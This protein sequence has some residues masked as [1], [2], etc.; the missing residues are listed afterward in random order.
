MEEVRG[1]RQVDGD[2][3]GV[4]LFALAV[5]LAERWKLLLFGSLAA[6]LA[7]LGIAFVIPPTFT[8]RTTFLPPQQQ[9]STV[10]SLLSSLGPLAGLAGGAAGLRTPADQYVA[11]MQSAT[12]ADRIIDGFQL[13]Q[14]YDEKLRVDARKE[15]AKNV[16]FTIGKKDGLITVE[17]D[18][19]TPQRAADIANRFVEELRHMTDT[20]AITE[21]QQRRK[22]FENQ[23][24]QTQE[25]LAQAQRALQASG[26]TEGALKAEPKA[27]AEGYASLK[28][29]VTAAE[30]RLSTLLGSMAEGAP[31][32]RQQRA[33]LSALRNQLAQLEQT[34]H[35]RDGPDYIGK[36]REFKYEET[37]FELLARQ[38]ELAK[39]DESREGALVQVVD[40]ATPPE[41]KSKPKRGLVAVGA[42]LLTGLLLAV[43]VL[44]RDSWQRSASEPD[45][46]E[47]VTRIRQA[48]GKRARQ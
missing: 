41:R 19:H 35:T 15:L 43:L 30:V 5:P 48:F 42:T 29:Q 45:N 14:V 36:Y 28:A 13:M 17:V 20:I 10:S 16:H 24:Q 7:A 3:E 39:I 22:F 46:A 18:D 37:L 33:A 26:M 4:S 31:E 11:L 12:V 1:L 40:R 2:D 38:Y 47:H 9:Q 27:A 34:S 25:R 6:G 8:A 32:V 21:A 44:M 23:L